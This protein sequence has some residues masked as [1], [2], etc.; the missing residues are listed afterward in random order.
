MNEIY[1][2]NDTFISLLN[3][4]SYLLKN[5]IKPNNI[6]KSN[7]CP[8]LLDN[9]INLDIKE[10]D[11]IC[12]DFIISFGDY[13]FKSIYYTYLSEE[14]NKELIIYYFFLNALKYRHKI[15]YMRNLKCVSKVLKIS[16]YVMHESH[17]LKGFIRFKELENNILY[18]EIEPTND[19][20]LIVSN[21]F[22]ERL[23]NEYWIIKDVKRGML[24][25][26]DKRNYYLVSK[27]NFKLAELNEAT[28][29]KQIE[30]LWKQ[31]YKT[32]GINERRNDR[33]RQNF[34]PKKY[35]KYIIE[36]KEEL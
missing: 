16:E 26:Y 2:Y 17:K 25:I 23:K 6:K 7:Y 12:H 18:A 36:V 27:E 19:V 5:N 9:I 8:T 33:C 28:H 15:T 31:F 34:M 22:K 35:W 29:E 14:E 20:L 13:A 24:S 10:D 11:K 30:E 1:I 3:L 4:I 32:I 21:H